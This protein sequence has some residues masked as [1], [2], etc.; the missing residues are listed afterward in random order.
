MSTRLYTDEELEELRS[1][2]KRVSNPGARWLPKPKSNP[3]HHQRSYQAA[4]ESDD[5]TRFAI[6]QRQNLDD[7]SDFSCGI[8]YLPPG[9]PSLTLARYNGPSHEH[10]DIAY[11]PHIHRAT[12]R[13]I[14]AGRKPE[15]EAEETNRYETLEGATA[16]LIDDFNLTGIRAQRDRP[17][18]FS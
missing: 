10:G 6:Y 16:C 9:G 15:S 14:A 11:R 1:K 2:P 8:S 7:E 12:E 18:L 17:R 3:G 4:E 5:E 13:A